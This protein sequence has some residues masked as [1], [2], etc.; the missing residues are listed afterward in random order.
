MT[1]AQIAQQA[2]NLPEPDRFELAHTLW[3]SL[4][5]PDVFQASLPLPKWQKQ[6]LDE[7]LE[8][9]ASDPGE[10][11]EQVKAEIWPDSR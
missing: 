3:A 11:W 2:L 10:E 9:S 5:E 4:K 6:L 1:K 8:A 7:R